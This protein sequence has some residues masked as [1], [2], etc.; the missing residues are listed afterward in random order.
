MAGRY[1]VTVNGWWCRAQSKDD[2]LQGDGKGDEVFISVNTKTFDK[3]GTLVGIGLDSDSEVM[4][5]TWRLPNR[6][7]AGQADGPNGMGGILSGDR[8]PATLEPWNTQGRL[9]SSRVPPYVIWEGDVTDDRA[10]FLT[11]TIWE[12]DPGNATYDAF[13][14]WLLKTDNTYGQRAK[15]IFGGIWPV[16]KPVFDAVSLGIQTVGSLSGIWTLFGTAASRPIG[17]KRDP[18]NADN[19]AYTFNAQ[20][21]AL[22]SDTAELLSSWNQNGLG[23]GIMELK[24]ADD[25]YLKGVYSIFVQVQKIG[26]V[27][28]PDVKLQPGWRWCSAC[29]GL[30]FG[31]LQADSA[32]PA[33]GPHTPQSTSHSGM[34]SIPLYAEPSEQR[35][36][37]WAWCNK[38]QGLFWGNAV[39]QSS[40]PEGGTH[41]HPD[42]SGSGRYS[43]FHNATGSPARQDDW[44]WCSACQGLFFN[45]GN[46][47]QGSV[48][49]AG[50]PH[51]PVE[52][53]RSGNYSLPH[54]PAA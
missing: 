12:W 4:G 35:Q 30:F 21:I 47:Q 40:C 41:T 48:C 5:D 46:S 3:D 45:G 17:I 42:L 33:G 24:Y 25:P 18:A 23:Q 28:V 2:A 31:E 36:E 22:T 52:A 27:G 54:R 29:Q 19:D 20:T 6:V 14:D 15:E 16:A 51:R 37:G 32:C 13:I 34:Y 26:G 39:A 1:R 11:P 10:T 44:R 38:C 49:P 7:K 8:F 53:T 50:G 43:L 9:N